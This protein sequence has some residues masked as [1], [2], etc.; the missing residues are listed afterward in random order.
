MKENSITI[1]ATTYSIIIRELVARNMLSTVSSLLDQMQ[2][3]GI[4]PTAELFN[5]L[6]SLF[7]S[8]G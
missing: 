7:G 2:N 6:L 1:N 4:G 3:S 8:A 5:S